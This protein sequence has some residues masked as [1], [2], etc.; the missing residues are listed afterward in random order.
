MQVTW[1]KLL[2]RIQ[3]HPLEH[4]GGY[5]PRLLYQ[6]FAGYSQALAVHNKPEIE[7]EWS[8]YRF[9]RWFVSNAYAGQ[10]GWASYCRLLTET[11]EKALDL[12]FEFLRIAKASDWKEEDSSKWS[13]PDG[14]TT[15]LDLIQSETFKTKP[16]LYFGNSGWLSGHWAMW[17]GYVW[18]E[19]DIGVTSSK[20][21]EV[22][23]GFGTWLRER[24]KFAQDANFGKLFEFLALDHQLTAL[25]NFFD[26][27]DLYLA[28]GTSDAHTPR[29]RSFLDDAIAD[30]L[31]HQA[32]SSSS[33]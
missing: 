19:R 9:N 12:F 1:D 28:G 16:A 22:F 20:D 27:L 5:S 8:L 33:D 30:A 24:Y 6:Y 31:K 4:L 25:E 13:A 2:E 17:N 15:L 11:D 29:F 3:E 14:S 10:Q 23:E 32:E 18:A 26:H 21:S 7:E